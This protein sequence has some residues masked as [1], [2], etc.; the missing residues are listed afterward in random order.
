[1][2]VQIFLSEERCRVEP[3]ELLPVLVAFP[4]SAGDGHH[5]IGTDHFRT[6]DVRTT[7][8]VDELSLLVERERFIVS[9]SLVDVFDFEIL[10][11]VGANL[12]CSFA[13]LFDAFEGFI[14]FDDLG[15]FGLDLFEVVFSQRLL[16]HEV[17]VEPAVSGWPKS[18]LN[19]LF[20][21]HHSAGHHMGAAVTH[22]P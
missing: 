11:H 8:E 4:V 16:Q 9:Q 17:V 2:L 14:E 20:D 12:Q 19:S 18:Q 13:R 10:F 15:H 5:F 3:L 7:A 22:R 6:G 1:M 21:S